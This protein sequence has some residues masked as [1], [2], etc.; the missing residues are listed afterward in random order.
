MEHGQRNALGA[1]ASSELPRGK[2]A[3]NEVVMKTSNSHLFYLVSLLVILT[4]LG[5]AEEESTL[6]IVG[7]EALSESCE[8]SGSIAGPFLGRGVV[9]VS[10]SDNYI[11]TPVVQS[12]LGNS[13]DVQLATGGG[14]ELD[15]ATVEGN[16]VILEGAEVSFTTNVA[17]LQPIFQAELFIPIGGT[18]FPNSSSGIAI[19]VI[20]SSIVEQ[21]RQ[22]GLFVTPETRVTILINIK[23]KGRTSSG[24]EVESTE[25]SFPLDICSRCLLTYPPGTLA[26]ANPQSP[27][28]CDPVVVAAASSSLVTVDPPEGVCL[29][30]QDSFVDC[31]LCRSL[32]PNQEQAN[33]VCDPSE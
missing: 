27:L 3:L 11:M 33:A 22:A 4:S 7:N 24:T 12:R 31:R 30:G 5:C 2:G 32:I 8:I 15:D 16:T 6:L 1:C 10:L 28:T 25:F 26:Q 21:I 13:D 14:P 9:D 23:F 17:P 29:F 20:T 19:E 18:I